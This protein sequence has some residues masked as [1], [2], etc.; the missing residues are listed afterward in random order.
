MVGK[1]EE[2]VEMAGRR[3][4][5]F[6]SLQETRWKG[7]GAR[8]I[9]GAGNWYKFYWLGGDEKS[10]GVGVL[11][12]DNWVDKVMDV[13]RCNARIM[14]SWSLAKYVTSYITKAEKVELEELWEELTHMSLSARLWSIGLKAL[15]HRQCG[16]YEG[17]DRLLGTHLYGKSESIRFVN[18]NLPQNR[19]RI[20]KS[21][22]EFE[23]IKKND[24]TSENIY[25]NSY[26]DTYYPNRPDSMK[27]TNLYDFMKFYDRLP[28][29]NKPPKHFLELEN[30]LGMLRKKD[31]PYVINHIQ[32][33]P[34]KSQ[35]EKEK[36][37]H[38]LLMLFSS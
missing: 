4:L 13:T 5:D 14:S 37:F 28:A 25:T 3:N 1:S 21:F 10:L 18:T 16:A 26:I 9:E 27:Q 30:G 17:A 6:C 19:N 34:K 11:M 36:Y 31:K 29:S 22:K 12:A 20:L 2:I 35:E 33:N 8:A 24:P 23:E 15:T 7:S 32:H 38:S